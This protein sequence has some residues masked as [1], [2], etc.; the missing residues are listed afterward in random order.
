M[1]TP[2]YMWIRVRIVEFDRNWDC[3]KEQG[4]RW[5]WEKGY[6]GDQNP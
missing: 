6:G 4:D 1:S 3:V 5:D 2:P